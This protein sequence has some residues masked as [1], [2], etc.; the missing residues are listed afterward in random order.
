VVKKPR[1]GQA[2]FDFHMENLHLPGEVE[3]TEDEL[4]AEADP[5]PSVSGARGSRKRART[6]EAHASGMDCQFVIFERGGGGLGVCGILPLPLDTSSR[7]QLTL[8]P[9]EY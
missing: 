4:E 2:S 6:E 9:K 1:T 8:P 5:G 3:D 7:C